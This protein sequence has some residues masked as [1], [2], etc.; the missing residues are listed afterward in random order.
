[1]AV[2]QS[3]APFGFTDA[4]VAA[5]RAHPAFPAACRQACL[6]G[7]RYYRGNRLINL[8]LGDR[9]RSAISLLCLYL[10][11]QRRD[12]DPRSGLTLTRLKAVCADQNLASP[13][14]IEAFVVLMRVLGFL[15]QDNDPDDRRVRRL[16]PTERLFAA[17]RDRWFGLM[18]AMTPVLPD[19]PALRACFADPTFERAF[20]LRGGENFL[21]GFRPFADAETRE[22]FGDRNAGLTIAFSLVTAGE[23][24]DFPPRGPVTLSISALARQFGVSRVHVR[25]L[26]R[27]ATEAGYIARPGGDNAGIVVKPK[28][29]D[30]I[31]GFFARTFLVARACALDARA[32]VAHR[33]ARRA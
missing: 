5:V 27:D 2:P 9:G 25:K 32:A 29:A 18:E 21:A 19:T 24:D 20:I 3:P 11:H 17:H 15:R 4:D 22:L 23:E 14:R 28:L 7:I 1:M 16:T 13:G 12:D 31:A 26:L 8:L 33:A 30:A 6:T 10:Y